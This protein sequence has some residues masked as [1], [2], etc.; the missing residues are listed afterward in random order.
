MPLPPRLCAAAV[1]CAAAAT[2]R[3]IGAGERT[4]ARLARGL[5]ASSRRRRSHG[6]AFVPLQHTAAFAVAFVPW[7]AAAPSRAHVPG[8]VQEK[9]RTGAAA[10]GVRAAGEGEALR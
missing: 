7:G 5:A 2:S 8:P 1:R 3:C 4:G 9:S 6:L 10:G